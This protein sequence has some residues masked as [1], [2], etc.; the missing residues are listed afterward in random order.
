MI[1]LTEVRL[2][3]DCAIDTHPDRANLILDAEHG[4]EL[5]VDDDRRF[6][7]ARW[8]KTSAGHDAEWWG[9]VEFPSTHARHWIRMNEAQVANEEV[10]ERMGWPK[11]K[12]KS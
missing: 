7:V 1:P 8:R 10:K 9:P 11:G 3:P 4:W 12:R 5:A 2:R 6:I